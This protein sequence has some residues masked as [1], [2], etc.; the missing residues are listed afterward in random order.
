MF[1]LKKKKAK[2]IGWQ[3]INT[4][5]VFWG[6]CTIWREIILVHLLVLFYAWDWLVFKG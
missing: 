3:V 6:K 2:V 1:T 5:I 4:V